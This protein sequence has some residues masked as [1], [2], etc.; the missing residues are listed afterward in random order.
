MSGFGG[1]GFGSGGFGVGGG[2]APPAI[3]LISARADSTRSVLVAFDASPVYL[4][5]AGL[6][7]AANTSLWSCV[8][9][10]E[11]THPLQVERVTSKTFILRFAFPWTKD[12]YTLTVTSVQ[13][14]AG[15]EC[16]APDNSQAFFGLLGAKTH[17]SAAAGEEMVDLKN[18]P[19]PESPAG[20]LVTD[21]GGN[22]A[23]EKPGAPLLRKLLL[24]RLTT[25][26]G[27]FFHLPDYGKSLREKNFYRTRD[28][29]GLRKAVMD[30]IAH[31]PGVV[32]A[33]VSVTL[34]A[35]G[36]LIIAV[37]VTQHGGDTESLTYPVPRG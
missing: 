27:A 29:I 14:L 26:T 2:G 6:H 32:A 8:L 17:Q 16:V 9:G 1:G 13:T 10:T 35:S 25:A 20:V 34:D 18:A 36:Q 37:A 12:A 7:D 33:D 5:P 4:S 21:S 11:T 19:T 28:L 23:R 24:R 31:E 30:E 3:R 22:Y 15:D